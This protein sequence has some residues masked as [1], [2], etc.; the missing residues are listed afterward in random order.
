MIPILPHLLISI[1]HSVGRGEICQI[2][3][4]IAIRFSLA[5]TKT[6]GNHREFH[7]QIHTKKVSI[8]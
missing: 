8:Y 2:K 4:R 7:S 3:A 1:E 5:I 6:A